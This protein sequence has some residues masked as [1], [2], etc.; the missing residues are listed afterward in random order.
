[1]SLT[2]MFV[3]VLSFH[4]ANP[5][6][7]HVL[8]ACCH[9]A[10]YIPV[11]RQ[12]AAQASQIERITLVSSGAIRSNL[13]SLGFRTT[14]IFEPLFEPL[15]MSSPAILPAQPAN[16]QK[17]PSPATVQK[18]VDLITAS[19]SP[20]GPK[21]VKNSG[22][23]RPIIR[24]E[25]GKRID[26]T[27]IVD[28]SVFQ[29]IKKRNLCSWHYLRADCQEGKCKREHGYQRPLGPAEYDALWCFTR[30][31]GRC[32]KLAKKGDC[33]DDQCVYGHG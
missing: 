18:Q 9:D 32:F 27:L 8:L 25:S 12:Y 2:K 16:G 13:R 1:M 11:L 19:R 17:P 7:E 28:P 6:C 26:K 31:Q 21:A 15:F 5:Q 4:V 33:E 20:T 23:L 3:E 14:S 24:D 22:R 29:A 30:Q 10:G